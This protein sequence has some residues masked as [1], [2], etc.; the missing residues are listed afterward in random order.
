MAIN[1]LLLNQA[2]L[3]QHPLQNHFTPVSLGLVIALQS[4]RLANPTLGETVAV[5]GLGLIGLLTVQ[6]LRANGC[7]VVGLDYDPLKLSLARQFGAEVVNLSE[8]SDPLHLVKTY[9]DQG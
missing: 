3:L 4:I 5:T 8:N 1:R 2:G 6:L 7:R 9:S